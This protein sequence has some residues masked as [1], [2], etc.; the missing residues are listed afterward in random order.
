MID[1]IKSAELNNTTVEKLKARFERFPHSHKKVVA[2]CDVGDEVRI[3]AFPDYRP[4][5]HKCA[6][7]TSEERD[8]RSK[9]VIERCKDP[10][11]RKKLSDSAN[12]RWNDQDAREKASAFFTEYFK[13]PE[14]RKLISDKALERCS[15]PEVLKA[16]SD[17]A[18]KQFSD[19][20]NRDAHSKIM[21]QIHKDNPKLAKMVSD[22]LKQYHIDN[23]EAGHR[24]NKSQVGGNDIINHHFIYDHDNPDQHTVKLTRSQH[25]AHHHWMRR[26]GLEVLHYNATEENNN[27]FNR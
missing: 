11:Y 5:C 27:I 22:S 1:W 16:M 25:A 2:I 17:R 12:K 23:P 21:I 26:N 15:D 3:L 24:N 8:R 20:V 4:L 18:I 7:G 9:I 19:Q 14:H 10:E 6:N 13:D